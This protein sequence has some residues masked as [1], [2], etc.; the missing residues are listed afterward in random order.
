MNKLLELGIAMTDER[1]KT[2][3]EAFQN[4]VKNYENCL[5][6]FENYLE[7]VKNDKSKYKTIRA[8]LMGISF[9]MNL[10]IEK[11]EEKEGE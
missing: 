11:S 1:I 7:S 10:L 4:L 9:K 5:R 6:D 8:H 3:D 2:E